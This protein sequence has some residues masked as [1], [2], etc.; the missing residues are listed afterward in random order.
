M[1]LTRE[2]IMAGYCGYSMSNNAVAAYDEGKKPISKWKKDNT[3]FMFLYY[4][5]VNFLSILF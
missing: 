5:M 2:I 1:L 4:S 3:H